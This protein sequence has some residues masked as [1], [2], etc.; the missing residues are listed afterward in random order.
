VGVVVELTQL[1]VLLAVLE[2]A[3]AGR[4]FLEVVVRPAKVLRVEIQMQTL[5]AL[6]AARV[7]WA[8]TETV[9]VALEAQEVTV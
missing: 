8:Q 4:G 3:Q 9:T 7:P 1:Q 2:A 5:A 6:V